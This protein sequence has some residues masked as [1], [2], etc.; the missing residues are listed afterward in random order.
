MVNRILL[1]L[2]III[3]L[4]STI[5][6]SDE[7]LQQKY[8]RLQTK[9]LNLEAENSRL[10]DRIENEFGTNDL[11][12]IKRNLNSQLSSLQG[13]LE[14]LTRHRNDIKTNITQIRSVS[15]AY[16]N[17]D[18][19]RNRFNIQHDDIV[20]QHLL[21]EDKNSTFGYI[22]TNHAR[23]IALRELKD[24]NANVIRQCYLQKQWYKE[25]KE[26]SYTIVKDVSWNSTQYRQMAEDKFQRV[27][28]PM[29][30]KMNQIDT[31]IKFHEEFDFEKLEQ[32]INP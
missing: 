32:L 29:E 11:F 6:C 28:A 4:F 31:L 21:F 23:R 30:N 9:V 14:N 8:D 25:L 12:Q 22:G 5:S 7:K 15:A 19:A 16:D 26:Q 3:L 24:I 2:L 27:I 18:E 13:E 1:G 17:V 10:E 20:A